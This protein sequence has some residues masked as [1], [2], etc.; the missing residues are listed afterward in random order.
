VEEAILQMNLLGH[1]FYMFLNAETGI[2]N[3]VYRRKDS[4]Y[5]LII[6]DYND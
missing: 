2:V 5:G 4:G 6:P 1:Q 3:V